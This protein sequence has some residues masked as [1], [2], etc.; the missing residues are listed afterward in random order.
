MNIKEH[1][2]SWIQELLR[3]PENQGISNLERA[4]LILEAIHELSKHARNLAAKLDS[5]N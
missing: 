3:A 1:V 5:V 2:D 4:K